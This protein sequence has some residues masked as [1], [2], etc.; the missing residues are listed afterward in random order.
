MSDKYSPIPIKP[1]EMKM[2]TF[3]HQ[4]EEPKRKPVKKLKN[5]R[6][7]V[8]QAL[9]A[10]KLQ[11]H[12]VCPDMPYREIEEAG[13]TVTVNGPYL[14]YVKKHSKAGDFAASGYVTGRYSKGSCAV[15]YKASADIEGSYVVDENNVCKLTI[16]N[17]TWNG[18]DEDADE[19]DDDSDEDAD[20]D[21][22][23]SDEDSDE[24]DDD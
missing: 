8:Q 23:D 10:W 12:L 3:V 9:T 13:G 2:E 18:P 19:D 17:I 22:D 16:D 7:I 21:D 14:N 11:D 5:I 20:E 24:D 6:A 1:G 4:Y 15:N